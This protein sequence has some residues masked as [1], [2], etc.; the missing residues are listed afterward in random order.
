[1]KTTVLYV[2]SNS[3]DPVFERKITDDLLEKIGNI[4]LVS[5]TQEPMDLGTN[6]CV[7][8][9]G[10]SYFNQFRQ[11]QIGLKA[12]KTPFVTI[13][14]ADC[15]YPPEYFSFEPKELGHYYRYQ[16]CW[17]Q[18]LNPRRNENFRFKQFAHFAQ[19][20]DVDLWLKYIEKGF[21]GE[22]E[23]YLDNKMK[24]CFQ[25]PIIEEDGFT[26]R[27]AISFKTTGSLSLK[28]PSSHTVPHQESV[29]YWGSA[30]LLKQKM[31]L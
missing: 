9:R 18:D 1:M 11:I 5:V 16:N 2:S 23:W 25:L 17:I 28:S 19:V 21:E 14:E 30:K 3:Q 8:K 4:S 20:I 22:P 13:A 10:C 31:L 29:D 24:Y 7:G 6:I 26:G 12:I 27:P 15:L